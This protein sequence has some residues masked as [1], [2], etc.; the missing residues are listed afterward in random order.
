MLSQMKN[1]RPRETGDSSLS[2]K[3]S[4]EK[5]RTKKKTNEISE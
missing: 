5:K 1:E 4:K 2:V 3:F